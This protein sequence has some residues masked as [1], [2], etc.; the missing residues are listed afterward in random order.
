MLSTALAD[1]ALIFAAG[2]LIIFALCVLLLV[3]RRGFKSVSVDTPM[4]KTKLE[5]VDR[6][7]RQLPEINAKLDQIN[8]AVNHQP[9]GAR[10]LVQRMID[11]EQE[12]RVHRAWE[13]QAMHTIAEHLGIPLDPPPDS[14]I[15]QEAHS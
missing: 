14:H 11:V 7:A 9:T 1:V 12:L 2:A 5:A 10:T 4:F 3:Y 6:V 8:T 15:Q 13:A